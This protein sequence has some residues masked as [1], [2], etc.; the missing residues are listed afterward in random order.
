MSIKIDQALISHFIDADLGLPI[1]HENLAYEPIAGDAY[2]EIIVL[3]NDITALNYKHTN[4][5][6]GVFRIILRYPQNYGAMVAKTAAETI[7]NHFS[8][9]TLLEYGGVFVE[10]TGGKRDPGVPEDGWYKLVLTVP[11]RA[12]ITR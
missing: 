6:D 7:L 4:Q 2:A 3:P 10:I 1:A 12:F 5:T 8:I 9:A 11:Y